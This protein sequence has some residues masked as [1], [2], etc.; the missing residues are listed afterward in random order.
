MR[1]QIIHKTTASQQSL[2]V[3]PAQGEGA[4]RAPRGRYSSNMRKALC[5]ESGPLTLQ[6]GACCFSDG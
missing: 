5:A 1:L 2:R 6:K 4:A 3:F